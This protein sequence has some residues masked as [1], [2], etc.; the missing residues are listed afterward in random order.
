MTDPVWTAF[1]PEAADACGAVDANLTA[2]ESGFTVQRSWSNASASAGHDPCVP[3]PAGQAYFNVAPA[4]GTETIALTVG[5][6]AT[7]DLHP[8]S[9]GPVTP[10]TL[11]LVAA[12]GSP[13]AFSP[14]SSTVSAGTV[15]ALTVTLESKPAIG[16]DQLYGLVSQSG[17]ELHVWPMIVQ[18]K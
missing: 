14:Q 17:S 8:F 12:S 10:W 11:S 6:S 9:D 13:L 16:G 5:Q 4:Q 1:G 2:S 15:A 3:V 7:V 18:A